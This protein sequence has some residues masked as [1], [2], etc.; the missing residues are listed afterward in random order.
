MH[1]DVVGRSL[2]GCHAL[3]SYYYCTG[4]SQLLEVLFV[5]RIAFLAGKISLEGDGFGTLVVG[6]VDI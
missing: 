5:R 1:L 2:R 3:W 6:D 4:H